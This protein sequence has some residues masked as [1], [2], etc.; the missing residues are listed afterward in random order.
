[1]SSTS[2]A[3]DA[4]PESALPPRDGP[5]TDTNVFARALRE[6]LV[7]FLLAGFAL[8]VLYALLQPE[9]FAADT[10]RRIELSATDVARVELAFVARW[11]RQPTAAELRGLLAS[12]VRNEILSREAI[13]LGLDKDDVIVKRRLAQKMEFLADD[14]SGL[15][16]PTAEELR[17]WFDANKSEFV[18]PSRITF[19][20]VYFSTDR[21]GADAEPAA[22]RA[23]ASATGRRDTAPRGDAFMFQDHYADRTEAQLAQVFGS[24]FAKTV[25]SSPL[26]QWSGPFESGLGWH[27]VWTEELRAG[28]VP[29][30]EDVESEVRERWTLEQ[31]EAAKRAGFE[32]MLARYEIVMPELRADSG[33]GAPRPPTR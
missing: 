29:S 11:Q 28:E 2:S 18:Q 5:A 33:T 26:K 30:Y 6:P 20:H 9:R 31:R 3:H 24:D 25:L 4:R 19:R 15:R 7:H 32:A 12:E 8:F 22:R 14:L 13:A 27:V 17:A 10:S 1:M 16:E 23:L 21:R